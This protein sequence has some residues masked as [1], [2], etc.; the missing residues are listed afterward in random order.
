MRDHKTQNTSEQMLM[1][2]DRKRAGGLQVY[3]TDLTL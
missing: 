1:A 3:Y 2:D